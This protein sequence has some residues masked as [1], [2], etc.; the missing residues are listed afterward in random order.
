MSNPN[1]HPTIVVLGSPNMDLIGVA[2]RFPDEGETIL[3]DRFFTAPGGKGGNQAV[4]VAR[5][6]AN[7]RMVGRVGKDAFGAQ[8]LSGLRGH[9][10][11]V[12][13][14]AGDPDNATGIAMILL[15]AQGQNR[16]V[17]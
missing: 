4:A 14:V 17:A 13:G 6:G 2:S 3:G 7:V 12:T 11:D 15:D 16:I 1:Q 5:M 8:L 10:I 9:G